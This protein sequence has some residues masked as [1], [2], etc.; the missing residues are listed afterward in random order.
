MRLMQFEN[1]F[2]R[3]PFFHITLV[4]READGEPP[5]TYA[6]HSHDYYVIMVTRNGTGM[7]LIDFREYEIT[8]GSVFF[9]SPNQVHRVIEEK[10]LSGYTIAFNDEFLLHSNISRH[11]LE[12]IN[13]FRPYGESPPLL[14]DPDTMTLLEQYCRDMETCFNEEQAFRYEALGA[15]LRLF[16]ISCNTVCNLNSTDI[17][18][19]LDSAMTTISAFKDLVEKKINTWHKASQYAE[20]LHISTNYLNKLNREY[21]HTSTKEYLQNRLVLETKRKLLT[22]GAS[23][24][25]IA[26][27]LGF[28]DPSHLSK[29]F[30]NCTGTSISDFRQGIRS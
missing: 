7:H 30:R 14:P 28:Q 21:L 16:L 8:P 29:M 22:S 13:L 5:K 26:Y 12:H 10:G 18:Q 20:A 25:E 1:T 15:H 17:N 19:T 4:N 27:D 9:L 11:F 3:D 2:E 23:A 6:P 24:K